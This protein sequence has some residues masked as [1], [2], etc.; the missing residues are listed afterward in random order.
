MSQAVERGTSPDP[1]TQAVVLAGA[2]ERLRP[3]TDTRPK[4]MVE[5]HGKPFL[6]YL[7]E[8]LREQGFE[9]VLLLLGYL[10]EAVQRHFGDGRRWGVRSTTRSLP[11][12]TRR[13]PA[14]AG[15]AAARPPLPPDVLRQLLPMAVRPDVAAVQERWAPAMV[16]VYRNRDGYTRD[17]VRLGSD[18]YVAAYDK[19]RTQPGLQ[20]VE[21][22]YL[23]STGTSCGCFRMRTSPSRHSSTPGSRRGTSSSPTQRTTGTTA[24][25]PPAAALT[26]EFLA[27]RPAVILDRDGVLNRKP[28]RAQYVRSWRSSTGSPAPLGA[29]PSE[30]GR[31]R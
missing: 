22:G 25:F 3:L 13:T 23:P 8:M 6:E 12:R 19:G 14:E 9:R 16:T 1:P 29:A 4:P 18:G 11:L 15:R 17:C 7:V 31:Y 2:R 10:P 20:G 21:I 27:R 30:P 24:W 5:I 26:E 28:A